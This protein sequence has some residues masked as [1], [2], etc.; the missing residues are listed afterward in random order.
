[1]PKII[2]LT[3]EEYKKYNKKVKEEGKI[4][5]KMIDKYGKYYENNEDYQNLFVKEKPKKS[6]TKKAIIILMK[7]VEAEVIPK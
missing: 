7:E 4:E 2:E 1:M 6:P 3:P 5:Q